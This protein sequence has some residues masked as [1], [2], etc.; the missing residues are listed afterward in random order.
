MTIFHDRVYGDIRIDDPLVRELIQTQ[1][2]QRLRDVDQSGYYD[3]HWPGTKHTRFEHS[4]GV[5]ELLR[6]HDATRAEQVAGLL[7]DISHSAFSHT[8]DYVLE[9]GDQKYQSYQDDIFIE[10]LR[11]SDVLPV[12]EK[13]GID[14]DAIENLETFRL[15]ETDLPDLCAD[16]IDYSLRGLL[17]FHV[18][19]ANEVRRLRECLRTDGERWYCADRETAALY[20]QRFRQL[21][22]RFYCGPTTAYTFFTSAA[23]FKHALERGYIT[24][25]DLY[26]TDTALL[27]SIAP[28]HAADETLR[29]LFA[30][31]NNETPWRTDPENGEGPIY[32][33]SRAID[34]LFAE[35]KGLKRLS[36][37]D[38]EW[39]TYLETGLEPKKY[40]IEFL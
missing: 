5:Y 1:T 11:R 18:A 26:G 8:I 9:A 7:H 39:K 23:Y 16:R 2:L 35:G 29:Q 3:V 15:L 22:E 38:N 25:D 30:R 34:P 17:I 40:H 32:C 36:E 24:H 4:L 21:N 6:R 31:M 19:N 10:H 14:F 13:Y 37:I 28:H 27:A 12:L 20:A 33:K